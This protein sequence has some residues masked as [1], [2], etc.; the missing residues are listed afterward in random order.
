MLG[1]PTSDQ[2]TQRADVAVCLLLA[3]GS[4]AYL[5][6][7]PWPL[8]SSDEAYFFLHA[9]RMLQ[10]ESLYLDVYE[11]TTPFLID[12]LALAFHLFGETFT[13]GRLIGSI[14]QVLM[15][16]VIYLAARATGA[17]PVIAIAAGLTQIAIAQPTWP[18]TTPHWLASLLAC[19]L[20]LLSLD[21]DRAR[22]CRWI[23]TNGLLLG[24]L[25]STRQHAG[26]AIGFGMVVLAVA[27]SYSDKRWEQKT[28]EPLVRHILLLAG[29]TLAG[30]FLVMGPHL[31][32]AGFA[33]LFEQLVVN[34][35][36][37][38]R[39]NLSSAWGGTVMVSD[40]LPF[41]WPMLLTYLPAVVAITA[42]RSSL[43]WWFRRN[44][45]TAESTLVL[46]VFGGCSIAYTMSF[47]DIVHL[48][49][50]MPVMLII[51]AEL[52]AAVIPSTNRRGNY[53]QQVLGTVLIIACTAQ[54]YRN[55]INASLQY[56]LTYETAFGEL[57]FAKAD[58]IAQ[59]DWLRKK[60]KGSLDQSLFAY[61]TWSEVYL[62]TGAKNPTRHDMVFPG[63]L[64]DEETNKLISS[65]KANRTAYV[66]PIWP[67][68]APGDEIGAYISQ[69]YH[70]EN[71]LVLQLCTRRESE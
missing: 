28:G 42:M 12:V 40:I 41:T 60:L 37:S 63:Y 54:M 4:F 6:L 36:T 7:R 9:I 65:L 11:I 21:R 51:A 58:K 69:Y 35:L 53:V 47:P 30:T 56:P 19:V 31:Y 59:I 64:N 50:I 49:I 8:G 44:R 45:K 20:L 23:V 46:A 52:T 61:P 1:I 43:A 10:G 68:I 66:I 3:I 33:P 16:I 26:V 57:R 48:A 14:I 22:R 71:P 2:W 15:V 18:Y 17:G 39:Q 27:D 70:C 5:M 38:Y 24:L 67:F 13:T 62:M 25:L 32:A 34:P 29:S 55:Y